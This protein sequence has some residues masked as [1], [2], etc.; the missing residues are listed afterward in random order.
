MKTLT[1]IIGCLIF[2][3]TSGQRIT[4]TRVTSAT[5]KVAPFYFL[6]KTSVAL[7][8]ACK[9][10]TKEPG[11]LKAYVALI[12]IDPAD[13]IQNKSIIYSVDYSSIGLVSKSV[14]DK[15]YVYKIDIKKRFLSKNSMALEYLEGGFLKGVDA[16]SESNAIPVI[17]TILSSAAKVVG[18]F[19]GTRALGL[20]QVKSP[21]ALAEDKYVSNAVVDKE[22][23]GK[24]ILLAK[25]LFDIRSRRN[26]LISCCTFGGDIATLQ[27]MLDEL[28]RQEDDIVAVFAGTAE[29]KIIKQ[30][31][32]ITPTDKSSIE[33][34]KYDP[35]SGFTMSRK[36][37]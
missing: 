32:E 13:A 15:N 24:A 5:E 27:K 28:Q 35:S 29:T 17:T 26:D 16:S 9:R 19:I 10:V 30:Q 1:T 25:S 8:I 4:V 21:L 36:D 6:P 20:V 34:F 2:L 11:P 22:N 18:S 3:S 14:F 12:G 23:L 31:F 33:L 37:T 7:E